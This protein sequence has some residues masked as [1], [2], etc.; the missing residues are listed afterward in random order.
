MGEAAVPEL[1]QIV[2]RGFD[3]AGGLYALARMWVAADA[4]EIRLSQDSRRAIL[5]RVVDAVRGDDAGSRFGATGALRASRDP[6][7]LPL[8]R[9]LVDRAER[10]EHIVLG[11]ARRALR[12]LESVAEDRSPAA[13]VQ[14][15]HRLTALI[16]EDVTSGPKR[17]ACRSIMNQLDAALRHVRAGRSGPTSNVLRA[18]IRR[19]DAARDAGAFDA[20]EHAIVAGG[21]RTVLERM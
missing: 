14:G 20:E 18:V 3:R 10:E 15:T 19:A 4:G 7:L 16:C 9:L 11:S 1:L 2:D 21:A 17:G 8:A 12:A 5:Q 13:M 6:S